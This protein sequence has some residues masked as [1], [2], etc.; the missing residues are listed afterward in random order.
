MKLM[1]LATA[2]LTLATGTAG[3]QVDTWEPMVK[4][5]GWPVHYDARIGTEAWARQI[6]FA[7]ASGLRAPVPAPLGEV[8]FGRLPAPPL[9][10][11]AFGPL[12]LPPPAGATGSALADNIAVVNNA[13][14]GFINVSQ[15]A[16]P[17]GLLMMLAG[18]GVIALV[19][20]RRSND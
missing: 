14:N 15:V 9:V 4:G 20:L 18:I 5:T 8:D 7:T 3:A 2:T 6:D 17:S 16:E 10:P 12:P 1:T 13:V 19:I 11:E